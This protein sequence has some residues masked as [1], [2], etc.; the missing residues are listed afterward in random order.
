MLLPEE[1]LGNAAPR[2]AGAIAV[3]FD[4]NF[5]RESAGGTFGVRHVFEREGERMGERRRVQDE[6]KE[7]GIAHDSAR[8]AV[9]SP[10]LGDFGAGE[11]NLFVEGDAC[12]LGRRS[13]NGEQEGDGR[14][15]RERGKE[16]TR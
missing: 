14:E 1:V 5:E 15:K 4:F 3:R 12:G 6:E 8:T 2:G 16:G 7:A 10:Q 13:P 9:P 11:G